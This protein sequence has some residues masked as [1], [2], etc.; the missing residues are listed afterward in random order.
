MDT[1]FVSWYQS[2]DFYLAVS[3]FFSLALLKQQ[4]VHVIC[5]TAKCM[6]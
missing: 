3:Y 5:E 4:T 1:V 2:A 6:Q